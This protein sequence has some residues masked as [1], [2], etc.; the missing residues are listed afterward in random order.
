MTFCALVSLLQKIVQLDDDKLSLYFSWQC[1]TIS[2][3]INLDAQDSLL[4]K[5]IDDI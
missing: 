1:V 4:S 3:T 2:M 5:L